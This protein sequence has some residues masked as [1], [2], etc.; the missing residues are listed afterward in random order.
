M[1]K[2]W[3]SCMSTASDFRELIPEFYQNNPNFL[4]NSKKLELGVTSEGEKV[5]EVNLPPWASSPQDFL[6][7][8]H[9]AL[10]SE[11]VSENLHHW[12]DL[13]FGYKQRGEQ[14]VIADNCKNYVVFHHYTY[15]GGID[16]DSISDQDLRKRIELQIQEF[17]Q[18]PKQ[19]FKVP[20]APRSFIPSV[21]DINASV[22]HHWSKESILRKAQSPI[23]EFQVHS[24]RISSLHRFEGKTISTSYDGDICISNKRISVLRAIYASDLSNLGILYSCADETVIISSLSTGKVISEFRAHDD[25]ISSVKCAN[26][27]I[28]VTGSWDCSLK[29]WDMRASFKPVY[30]AKASNEITCVSCSPNNP[31]LVASGD[32]LGNLIVT[33]FRIG[34]LQS[35]Q[36]GTYI[37]ALQYL[38]NEDIIVCGTETTEIIRNSERVKWVNIGG[39]QTVASDGDFA[40]LGKE[41]QELQLWQL[42]NQHCLYKWDEICSITCVLC[43]GEELIAGNIEGKIYQIN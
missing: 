6:S 28:V 27:D 20:H 22:K 34:C 14:A 23:Q 13:I 11:Y 5:S 7:K 16:L 24:R 33:D 32:M 17:G 3:E 40:Y 35:Q 37:F 42:E 29:L 30:W 38:N 39:V 25:Q 4:I 9:E 12:I 1:K 15:E 26:S 36:V 19:L 21:P 43:E 10:E 31:Y 18:T 41:E 2:E 8:M